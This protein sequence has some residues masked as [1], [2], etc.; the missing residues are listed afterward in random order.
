[1]TVSVMKWFSV[2]DM[3]EAQPAEAP[4]ITLAQQ[5]NRRCTYHSWRIFRFG[6]R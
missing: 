6:L 1:M 3:S 2:N 5:K 4:E